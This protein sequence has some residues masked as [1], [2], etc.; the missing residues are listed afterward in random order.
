MLEIAV[1]GIYALSR[2]IVCDVIST[3]I[4]IAM[5]SPS[6]LAKILRDELCD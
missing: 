4:S 5:Q 2:F 6:R 3:D 1:F